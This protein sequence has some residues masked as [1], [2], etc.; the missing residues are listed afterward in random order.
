MATKDTT[1]TSATT[2]TPAGTGTT[3][4]KGNGSK[5]D[6]TR[7]KAG[8]RLEE[9]RDKATE[10]TQAVREAAGEH[11]AR[12]QDLVAEAQGEL[13]TMVRRNPGMALLGAAGL[14]LLVGLAIGNANRR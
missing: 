1:Q 7:A 8:A 6:T 12:G 2:A 13:N 11:L 5:S 4:T 9:V 14:G 3:A 10:T